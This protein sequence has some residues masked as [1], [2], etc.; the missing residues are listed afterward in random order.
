MF[1]NLRR[2]SRNKPHLQLHLL[3]CL[4]HSQS[5]GY[6]RNRKLQQR[7]REN[8]IICRNTA[9]NGCFEDAFHNEEFLLWN[10]VYS[11]Y[12]VSGMK[13][14][15]WC[16]TKI[17]ANY[18]SYLHPLYGVRHEYVPSRKFCSPS[19]TTASQATAWVPF[20]GCACLAYICR[21]AC[22]KHSSTRIFAE[23]TPPQKGYPID[24]AHTAPSVSLR[25]RHNAVKCR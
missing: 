4:R 8:D 9:R 21:R 16:T 22:V 5:S 1:S 6:K 18:I 25:A 12:R 17:F 24:L 19:K 23:I 7:E 2:H 10:I 15:F 3:R 14:Y 11:E 13:K 20:F